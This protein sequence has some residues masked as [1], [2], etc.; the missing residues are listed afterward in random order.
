MRIVRPKFR[1]VM[2]RLSRAMASICAGVFG[3]S[4]VAKRASSGDFRPGRA[5][6]MVARD[7]VIEHAPIPRRAVDANH[8]A[9]THPNGRRFA[10]RRPVLV[11]TPEVVEVE[12]VPVFVVPV[13][14]V[15]VVPAVD[16]VEPVP[17]VPVPAVVVVLRPFV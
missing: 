17:V 14:L 13:P 1:R 9:P 16:P 8:P 4:S 2:V 12:A 6:R 5:S 15:P 7:S 3:S 11:E 10:Q